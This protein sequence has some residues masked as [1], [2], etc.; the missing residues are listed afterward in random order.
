MTNNE[1]SDII[2]NEKR[3]RIKL[4]TK[5]NIHWVDT[6]IRRQI[7]FIE[8]LKDRKKERNLNFIQTQK[9]KIKSLN[10]DEV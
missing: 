2:N 8:K 9:I 7:K 4:A 1:D 10:K 5:I 6:K 3:K